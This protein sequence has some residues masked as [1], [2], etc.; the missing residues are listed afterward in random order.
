MYEGEEPEISLQ[1]YE[2]FLDD[3]LEKDLRS[4]TESIEKTYVTF[5]EL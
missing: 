3:V 1:K 4:V 2:D 5:S